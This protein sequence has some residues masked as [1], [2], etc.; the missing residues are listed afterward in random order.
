M[1]EIRE[2]VDVHAP[3]ERVW[4]WLT[5][6]AEHYRDWHPGHREA[7]WERGQPHRVGSVLRAVED[8]GGRREV[9]RLELTA[10]D[11][12]RRLEYR[13]RGPISML[14]PRGAFTVVP[15]DEGS[16]FVASIWYRFGWLTE[17]LYR[18]RSAALRE[19]MHEEG[20]NLK[21]ILE[22]SG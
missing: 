11:P 8:L 20:E 6:I 7:R 19:H 13:F 2:S 18:R 4:E 17:H 9:L 10:V 1:R 3:P 16:L 5:G 22:A 21:R 12:P 14:L 15:R